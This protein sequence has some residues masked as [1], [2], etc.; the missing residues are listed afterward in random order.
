MTKNNKKN[1]QN[2][3]TTACV[4]IWIT[5]NG[6][7]F[8]YLTH[9]NQESRTVYP[10]WSSHTVSTKTIPYKIKHVSSQQGSSAEA[11]CPE[12]QVSRRTLEFSNVMFINT[13][14]RQQCR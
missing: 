4:H 13:R 14:N 5:E 3:N 2:V 9:E 6:L 1:I 8:I 10:S 7:E 12:E 11:E